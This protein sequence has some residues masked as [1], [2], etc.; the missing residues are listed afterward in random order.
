MILKMSAFTYIGTLYTQNKFPWNIV[1]VYDCS[2]YQKQTDIENII[3]FLEFAGTLICIF[4]CFFYFSQ[5][6][7]K[8]SLNTHHGLTP[9][10]SEH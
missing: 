4:K 3:L 6:R 7:P 5:N 9:I 8:S 2:V 10:V 1:I